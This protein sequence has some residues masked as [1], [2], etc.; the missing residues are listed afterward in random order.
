MLLGASLCDGGIPSAW[1]GSA[2]DVRGFGAVGDGRAIDT[3]A[4]N[5]AIEAA[6]RA[7]GGTV[8]FPPGTYACFSIRLKSFVTLYLEPGATI[9]AADPPEQGSATAGYDPAE[10][11]VPWD[12]Y[13]DFGHSHWHNSLIWGEGLHDVAILG[14]GRIW[15]RGLVRERDEPERPDANLPGIGNKAIALK[16]CYNVTLRDIS[17][18]AGGHFAILA[19]GVDNLTIDN[20][21]IDTNRDGMDIDCCRNV[22]IANCSVNSPWDDGI[23]LKSSLALGE[24]RITENVTIS[25]CALFGDYLLGTLLD[26]RFQSIGHEATADPGQRTGRIKLGTE[27]NGGFRNITI[28]NCTFQSCRGVAL[29]TVDGGVLEDV[30]ITG[31][32]MRD[33]RNS[34]LFLRLGAR[35]RGPKGT[36]PGVLRRVIVSDMVCEAPRSAMPSIISG[37]PGHLVEDIKIS[38]VYVLQKG[39]GTQ[40]MAALEPPELVATYP[41]P[42]RFGLLPAQGFF[43]RH[44]RNLEFSH[45]EIACDSPDARPAFWMFDVEGVDIE[46]LRATRAPLS[47]VVAS[48]DVRGLRLRDSLGVA[49]V[50]MR[51][52]A[53]G[54]R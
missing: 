47:S 26:G 15:G 21:K 49:D 37:V 18:L 10:P 12:A 25:D 27:S 7:G 5:Q 29:E 41:D 54:K 30:T 16:N 24:A 42:G 43:I 51:N 13:Q 1:A 33:L 48:R 38:D 34:P 6:A 36:T 17:I 19:T 52:P 9:L 11:N 28:A 20:V 32:T 46:R 44:A 53:A 39:G 4:V 45:I 23:C 35:L 2:L 22:R 31:V 3:K 40:A 8:R 50:A 14:P